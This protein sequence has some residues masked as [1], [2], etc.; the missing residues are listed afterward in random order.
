MRHRGGKARKGRGER[1]GSLGAEG[2]R[3]ASADPRRPGEVGDDH[4]LGGLTASAGHGARRFVCHG[5]RPRRSGTG[6]T[7][8]G[9]G[10]EMGNETLRRGRVAQGLRERRREGRG[11]GAGP[12]GGAGGVAGLTSRCSPSGLF[13]PAGPEE[14]GMNS[15]PRGLPGTRSL[16]NGAGTDERQLAPPAARAAEPQEAV[17]G[18]EVTYGTSGV[19]GRGSGS[20]SRDLCSQHGRCVR[21]ASSPRQGGYHCY[22][23]IFGLNGGPSLA[24]AQP[25]GPDQALRSAR[26]SVLPSLD[27]FMCRTR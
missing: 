27:F 18:T 15:E 12:G 2:P 11:R 26:Q 24:P 3:E 20:L 19:R 14:A 23:L 6:E 17:G 7:E 1:A 5:I 25:A 16:G 22:S 13:G 21:R 4:S 8:S 9:K 10:R